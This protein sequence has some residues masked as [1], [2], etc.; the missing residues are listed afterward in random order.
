M[1]DNDVVYD[2]VFTLPGDL[3]EEER[4]LLN[5]HW[6]QIREDAVRAFAQMP[7]MHQDVLRKA[8]LTKF[9]EKLER[10]KA[11]EGLTLRPMND[12]SHIR[13]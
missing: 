2:D 10:K 3:T 7:P 5:P 4:A 1:G 13:R 12:S 6:E 9:L 8:F 11:S